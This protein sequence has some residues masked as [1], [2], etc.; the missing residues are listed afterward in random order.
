[1]ARSQVYYNFFDVIES[2]NLTLQDCESYNLDINNYFDTVI[3][4]YFLGMYI[5][6]VLVL[7][8]IIGH[9]YRVVNSIKIYIKLFKMCDKEDC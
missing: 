2:A 4:Y 8:S 3:I 1:M 9:Y 5:A 6:I 7:F